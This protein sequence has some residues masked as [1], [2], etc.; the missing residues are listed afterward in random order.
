MNDMLSEGGCLLDEP[1]LLAMFNGVHILTLVRRSIDDLLLLPIMTISHRITLCSMSHPKR[2]SVVM[3]H[4]HSRTRSI[5][6]LDSEKSLVQVKFNL[7][8]CLTHVDV[9]IMKHLSIDSSNLQSHEWP[10]ALS[11]PD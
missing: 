1:S 9:P 4:D 7:G 2:P 11:C 6:E 5:R 3:R 10:E 8:E